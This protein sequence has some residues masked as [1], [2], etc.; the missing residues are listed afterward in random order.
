[1]SLADF[2]SRV[3]AEINRGAAYD[4]DIPYYC[5]LA[6]RWIER[7]W[8]FTYM[9]R[10]V[11]FSLKADAT[12]PRSFSIPPGLKDIR[13]VRLFPA[14]LDTN[15]DLDIS[16]TETGTA[17]PLYQVEPG[18][19]KTIRTGVPEAFW[20]DGYEYFWLDKVPAEDYIG[21][22]TYYRYTEWPEDTSE[23][24]LLLEHGEDL[25]LARTI[26]QMAPRLRN[27]VLRDMYMPIFAEGLRTMIQADEELAQSN[28]RDYIQMD[29]DPPYYGG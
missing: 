26:I 16:Q 21:Q 27:P 8:S 25:L 14:T 28:R 29:L 3:S 5:R 10:F 19:I 23:T 6:V 18:E 4:G 13:F 2:Y 20:R 9:E 12:Y 7:N 24:P 22:M 17:I 11:R 1:M 15:G